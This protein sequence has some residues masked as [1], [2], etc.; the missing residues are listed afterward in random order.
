MARWQIGF[1]AG[2]LATVVLTSIVFGQSTLTALAAIIG[3]AVALTNALM[4]RAEENVART[5]SNEF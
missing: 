1:I 5:S 3:V 2:A 4:G